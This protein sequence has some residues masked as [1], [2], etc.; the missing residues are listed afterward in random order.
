ML[1]FEAWDLAVIA[2]TWA[3]YYLFI[4]ILYYGLGSVMVYMAKTYSPKAATNRIS[5]E[6]KSTQV[7]V[8]SSLRSIG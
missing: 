6:Q 3:F 8:L 5:K 7:F 4:H 2:G 1:P